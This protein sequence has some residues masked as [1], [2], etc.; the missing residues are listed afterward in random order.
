MTA[1][2]T[3]D[4]LNHFGKAHHGLASTYTAFFVCQKC[5]HVENNPG[6]LAN[7]PCPKCNTLIAA[8]EMLFTSGN[9]LLAMIFDCYN[10]DAASM[11]VLLYCCLIEQLIRQILARRCARLNI[12]RQISDLLLDKYRGVDQRNRLFEQLTGKALIDALNEISTDNLI[13]TY[14]TLRKK[15]NALA[16]GELA[17]IVSITEN[18]IR[19]AVDLAAESFERFAQL[20]DKF[21]SVDGPPSAVVMIDMPLTR[22]L[23]CKI[24]TLQPLSKHG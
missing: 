12:P 13:E 24:H 23:S 22:L 8:R 3:L 21:C 16:H 6:L 15:R 14:N 1:S 10:T 4:E 9:H 19:T 20:H 5:G 18:D 17:G 2:Q 7:Q 11:C